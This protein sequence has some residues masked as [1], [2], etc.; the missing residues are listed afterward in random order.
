MA[1]DDL[2]EHRDLAARDLHPRGLGAR[3]QAHA[4]LGHHDRVGPLDR[5]VVEHRDRLR[6]DAHDVVDVHGDAVDADGVEA[7]GLLG[8]DQLGADA[9]GPDRD[10]EVR[11]DLEHRRVVARR[12]HRARGAARVDRAQDVDQRAHGAVGTALVHAGPRVRARHGPGL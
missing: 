7:P 9:V 4:D 8:H 12:E 5:Q 3:L 1:A 2:R 11:C 6:A 10:P